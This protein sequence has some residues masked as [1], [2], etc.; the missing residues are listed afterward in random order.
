MNLVPNRGTVVATMATANDPL[1]SGAPNLSD[2]SSS[3]LNRG[4]QIS[5]ATS[6]STQGTQ[7]RPAGQA[8][9]GKASGLV[10]VNHHQVT[11]GLSNMLKTSRPR[12]QW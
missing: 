8:G 7:L 10:K 11:I 6:A 12:L 5:S 2:P 9:L 1:P 4:D 3:D